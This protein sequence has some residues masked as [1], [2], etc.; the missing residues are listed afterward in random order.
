MTIKCS[1]CG[2]YIAHEDL[3]N[4]KAKYEFT[5]DSPFGAEVSCWICEKCK[6]KELRDRVIYRDTTFA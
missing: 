4:G 6:L 3:E 1:Y 5:P 2:K